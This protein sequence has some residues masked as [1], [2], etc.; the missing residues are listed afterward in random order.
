MSTSASHSRH[1]VNRP[2]TLTLSSE[3]YSRKYDYLTTIVIYE[4]RNNDF[5]SVAHRFG[6]FNLCFDQ[7]LQLNTLTSIDTFSCLN[8]LDVTHQ[9]AMR[10]FPGLIPSS[11]KDLYVCSFV[12]LLGWFYFFVQN[13]LFV[14]DVLH[15]LSQCLF[16]Q[17]TLHTAKYVTDYRDIKIQTYH[18]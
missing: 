9:T 7:Q 13:T 12:L 2:S 16:I 4:C 15:F 14:I 5:L 18:H 10:E 8:G 11:G 1:A 17:Y 3:F 6:F